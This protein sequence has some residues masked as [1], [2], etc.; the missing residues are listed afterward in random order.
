LESKKWHTRAGS[1]FGPDDSNLARVVSLH[2]GTISGADHSNLLKI[3]PHQVAHFPMQN[4]PVSA[5]SVLLST[6]VG[7]LESVRA[8]RAVRVSW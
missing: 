3:A 5:Y 1:A 6:E 8:V 2:I 7:L 4:C